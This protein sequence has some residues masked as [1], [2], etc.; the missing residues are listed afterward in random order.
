MNA[1]LGA[2]VPKHLLS[3]KARFRSSHPTIET[4]TDRPAALV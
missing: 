4:S 2:C 3:A 1:G